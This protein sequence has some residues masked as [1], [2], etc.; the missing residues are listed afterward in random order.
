MSGSAAGV[1]GPG[2]VVVEVGPVVGVV[3]ESAEARVVPDRPPP[4]AP[5]HAA[6]TAATMTVR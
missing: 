5:A 4:S 6:N 3:A 1:V 2:G